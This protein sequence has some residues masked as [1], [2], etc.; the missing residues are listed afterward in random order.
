MASLKPTHSYYLSMSAFG[1]GLALLGLLSFWLAEHVWQ[2][3]MALTFLGW[4]NALGAAFLIAWNALKDIWSWWHDQPPE[5]VHRHPS[6]FR[7]LEPVLVALV[8]VLMLLANV[9]GDIGWVVILVGAA[10][11]SLEVQR[12]RNVRKAIRYQIRV[13]KDSSL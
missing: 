13:A 6:F 8:G 4:M 11:F 3:F 2:G 9:L 5:I 7:I 12:Q 1:I 10:W